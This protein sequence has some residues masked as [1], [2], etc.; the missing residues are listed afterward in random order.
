MR[1]IKF[2]AWDKKYKLMCDVGMMSWCHGGL[3]VDGHGVHLGNNKPNDSDIILMQ[4]T[5]LKD[6]NG[7]D[8]YEGDIVNIQH[9]DE[10]GIDDD[11]NE[12]ITEE[13]YISVVK[14]Y[15]IIQADFGDHELWTLQWASDAD[16]IFEVIGNIHDNNELL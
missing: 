8:I 6:K 3:H 5:G 7:V 16:Y 12:F 15:N 4:Y 2:R 10:M 13:C 14:D 1:E 9:Y 11:D